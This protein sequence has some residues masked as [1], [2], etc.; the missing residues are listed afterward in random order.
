MAGLRFRIAPLADRGTGS[1]VNRRRNGTPDRGARGTPGDDEGRDGAKPRATRAPIAP[2]RA[3]G[4]AVGIEPVA[5]RA[6]AAGCVL[7][8]EARSGAVLEPPT[9]VAGFN[10]LAVMG[11]PVEKCSS[12]LDFSGI[13]TPDPVALVAEEQAAFAD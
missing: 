13:G 3:S 9:I 4:F 1:H 7:G 2:Q 8:C 12:H 11:Q 6:P 10:D 5:E